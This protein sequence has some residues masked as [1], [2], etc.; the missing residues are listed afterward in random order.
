MYMH[1]QHFLMHKGMENLPGC[2]LKS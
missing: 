2:E 1:D